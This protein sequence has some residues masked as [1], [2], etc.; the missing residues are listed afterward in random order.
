MIGPEEIL[1]KVQEIVNI[2]VNFKEK[3]GEEYPCYY[4]GYVQAC[5]DFDA[6]QPH[7]TKGVFPERLFKER[8]PNETQMEFD[9]A[10]KNFKQ[11][12]MSVFI[13]FV[14]SVKRAFNDGNWS[15]EYGEEPYD[16]EDM[17]FRTYVESG[18]KPFNSIE[19]WMKLILPSIKIEDACGVIA[20]RPSALD[21]VEVVDQ[22]GSVTYRIDQT[23]L[24]NPVPFY[25][26][27]KQVV[28][29]KDS[30][31][32]LIESMDKSIISFNGKQ[33]KDGLI[34]EYYDKDSI[35]FIKQ[36]GKKT[37]WLFEAELFWNH[38][39]GILPVHRLMGVPI[40]HQN[41]IY[42]QSP[43]LYATDHLDLV[44]LNESRLQLCVDKSVYPVRVMLGNE[45]EFTDP[46][47]GAK[48]F[49]GQI[50]IGEGKYRNCPKCHGTGLI[51]RIT[52]M[53]DFLIRPKTSV[54]D[55]EISPDQAIKYAAPD[56]TTLDFLVRK[57]S[58][59]ESRARKILHLSTSSSEVKGDPTAT[60]MAIDQKALYSFIKPISDEMFY[61]Y[62]FVLNC[63]GRQR[64]RDAFKPPVITYP[65]SFEFFTA[66]DYLEQLKQ[67]TDANMPP[68]VIQAILYK[69][70]SSLYYTEKETARVFELVIRADR[71]LSV[72]IDDIAM[73]ISR[74][75]ASKWEEVL[76]VS[77][78]SIIMKLE[79]EDPKFWDMDIQDQINAVV[80]ASK[81]IANESTVPAET[82]PLL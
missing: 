20:V 37:D 77:A 60:G 63:I 41:K 54:N 79:R 45:C 74:G 59:D 38:N 71:L 1:K 65:A 13:D 22:N 52:P 50:A 75:T 26:N 19:N 57:K 2:K 43:F 53:G 62:E 30:E 14:N 42:F 35:W 69:F 32:F 5:R 72:G 27:V 29:A 46:Q 61:L 33:V 4:P 80:G 21:F 67:A 12:T 76:H 44:L 81:L 16:Q 55:G 48:C 73:M 51:S 39:T 7:S 31:Y 17:Q 56:V 36:V 3:E 15:I 23:K 70:L 78:V 68:F 9:H 34:Y 28:H 66:D 8:A 6:I 25:F 49:D 40:A 47:S 58:E 64:Y 11:V 82:T 24:V 18:I 10:K